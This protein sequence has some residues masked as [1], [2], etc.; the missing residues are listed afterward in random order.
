MRAPHR[1]RTQHRPRRR[2]LTHRHLAEL[3]PRHRILP[4]RLAIPVEEVPPTVVEEVLRT[5]A[6][7]VVLTAV[8]ARQRLA[9]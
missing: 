3:I 5:A 7:V 6:V 4:P 1:V 2:G 9:E 8:T